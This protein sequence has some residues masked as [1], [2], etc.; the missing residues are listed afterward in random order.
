[1]HVHVN[2]FIKTA[3]L[4]N[5]KTIKIKSPLPQHRRQKGD[6]RVESKTG[7]I[8]SDLVERFNRKTTVQ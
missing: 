3:Q 8:D 4:I 2:I 1:M 6:N 7:S 5:L